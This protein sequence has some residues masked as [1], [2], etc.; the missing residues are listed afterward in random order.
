[1]TERATTSGRLGRVVRWFVLASIGINALLGLAALLG[2][3]DA[4]SGRVLTTSLFVTLGGLLGLSAWS[5]WIDG[6]LGPIPLVGM[7]AAA[8]GVV[9]LAAAV[10]DDFDTDALW[11]VGASAMIIAAA[12]SVS[13]II[14]RA[15]LPAGASWVAAAAHVLAAATALFLVAAILGW[16]AGEGWRAFGVLVVLLAAAIVAVP[17]L[18]KTAS[19][20]F[21]AGHKLTH[22]PLCGEHSPGTFGTATRC[23]T[24]E[25][26]Y[27]VTA[28][29]RPSVG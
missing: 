13:S 2:S 4:T 22:C 21:A 7:V 10:W 29:G 14:S 23:P 28:S 3:G 6:R 15:A 20:T 12:V 17:I 9:G 11:R 16:N 1:M 18:G 8:I 24:C 5:A 26:S 19:M 27:R 25:R